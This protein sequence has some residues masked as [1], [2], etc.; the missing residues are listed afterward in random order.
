MYRYYSQGFTALSKSVIYG[1][2]AL[3]L[4]FTN[5][6][7]VFEKDQCGLLEMRPM[8]YR[9]AG[10]SL[11]ELLIVVAIILIIAAIAIPSF[12]QAKI[13]ANESSAVS[14]IHAINTAEISY[15]STYSNI[16]FSAALSDLGTG[17]T[18]ACPPV[19]TSTASCFIDPVLATGTK[20]GYTF[21]YVQDPTY[22]P[23]IHFTINANPIIQSLTGQK[24]FYSDDS[25]VIRYNSTGPATLSS[26]PI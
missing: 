17:G 7:I 4:H 12:I 14:S 1:D 21:T 25:N 24:G 11:I 2:L 9:Q 15:S 13:S 8:K 3:Y 19:A 16:G 26:Q 5:R 18:N 6:P 10:F 22:T 20:A 23:A